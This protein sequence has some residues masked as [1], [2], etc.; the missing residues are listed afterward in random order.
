M[1]AANLPACEVGAHHVR[2]SPA[3]FCGQESLTFVFSCCFLGVPSGF[4]VVFFSGFSG[5]KDELL[6]FSNPT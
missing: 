5:Q 6:L 4:S 3:K 2:Y 1:C